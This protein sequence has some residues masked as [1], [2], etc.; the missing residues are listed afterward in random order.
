M[1]PS[2]WVLDRER[3]HWKRRAPSGRYECRPN[4][5]KAWTACQNIV[6]L[7]S[8]ENRFVRGVLIPSFHVPKP[9]P[10]SADEGERRFTSSSAVFKEDRVPVVQLRQC[11]FDP[12]T[13]P[14]LVNP[15]WNRVKLSTVNIWRRPPHRFDCLRRRDLYPQ[16]LKG[17]RLR[18][19]HHR[20][21]ANESHPNPAD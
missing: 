1:D 4:G 12:G 10:D 18:S 6:K 16:I 20:H 13:F 3:I 11:E 21:R 2:C 15:K 5:A 9:P 7:N 8:P 17:W 14:I 19:R